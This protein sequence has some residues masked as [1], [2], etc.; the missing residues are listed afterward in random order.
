MSRICSQIHYH[1][2]KLAPLIELGWVTI[3]NSTTKRRQ[4][5]NFSSTTSWISWSWINNEK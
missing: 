4:I 1:L 5:K 3:I 2:S